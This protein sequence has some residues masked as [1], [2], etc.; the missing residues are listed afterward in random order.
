MW[1]DVESV[2]S[3]TEAPP[4]ESTTNKAT[5]SSNSDYEEILTIK[6]NVT[7]TSA[8]NVTAGLTNSSSFPIDEYWMTQMGDI[9][10]D[11]LHIQAIVVKDE[12]AEKPCTEGNQKS[13]NVRAHL[14]VIIAPL[15]STV[16]MI[17]VAEWRVHP[18]H[19]TNPHGPNHL[20]HNLAILNLACRISSANYYKIQ[21]PTE[22]MTHI[23]TEGNCFIA[24][25][26]K[27]SHTSN[28]MY[29]IP[30]PQIPFHNRK[31]RRS[32]EYT[33]V[34]DNLDVKSTDSISNS[35]HDILR[36]IN[37][38]SS[39]GSNGC[40]QSGAA[41]MI[42]DT[43]TAVVAVSCDDRQSSGKWGFT[44]LYKNLDWI[45]NILNDWNITESHPMWGEP[46]VKSSQYNKSSK[47]CGNCVFNF[48]ISVGCKEKG[49]C[50][51]NN[52]NRPINLPTVTPQ[53]NRLPNQ[54][55]NRMNGIQIQ[56][57]KSPWNQG[58]T[59][60]NDIPRL[61]RSSYKQC[62]YNSPQC[63]ESLGQINNEPRLI[64]IGQIPLMK[65]TGLLNK[66]ID[67]FE[68]DP[69][70]INANNQ[71]HFNKFAK[72]NTI[73][74]KNGGVI[75]SSD[76]ASQIFINKPEKVSNTL[77]NMYMPLNVKRNKYVQNELSDWLKRRQAIGA[78][79]YRGIDKH[80]QID[81]INF[82]RGI[83]K[84]LR[85]RMKREET[86]E[87]WITKEFGI[88]NETLKMHAFVVRDENIPPCCTAAKAISQTR[89][90]MCSG[91][92]L[93]TRHAI[94]SASCMHFADVYEHHV[95]ADLAVLIG[96]FSI[97]PYVIKIDRY[98]MHPHHV[99]DVDSSDL[100][101]H[102]L[103]ILFLNCSI[104]TNNMIIPRLPNGFFDDIGHLC[105]G[106]T[107]QLMTVVQHADN[108][109]VAKLLTAKHIPTPAHDHGRLKS[110][111]MEK[112]HSMVFSAKFKKNNQTALASRRIK[113]S[114]G[115][116]AG[117][118]T[119]F[120]K[121]PYLTRSYS[122][123]NNSSEPSDISKYIKI[124][125]IFDEIENARREISL[126]NEE[127]NEKAKL[128]ESQKKTESSSNL[129]EE[130]ITSIDWK[131][132]EEK[133]GS[134]IST[135]NREKMEKFTKNLV[136]VTMKKVGSVIDPGASRLGNIYAGNIQH[137]ENKFH[138]VADSSLLQTFLPHGEPST[139][140]HHNVS[141]FALAFAK[142]IK[143]VVASPSNGDK[144]IVSSDLYVD[145]N[146]LG[147]PPSKYVECPPLGTPVF[148]NG[149]LASLLKSTNI[150]LITPR[151]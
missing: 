42:N 54:E 10:D 14:A 17:R 22:A 82:H 43:Q 46:A 60:S 56:T 31:R 80:H 23:C 125:N 89:H 141:D 99:Y 50:P 104:L 6:N 137:F 3:S 134:K 119:F 117:T 148:K 111:G 49:N 45:K 85:N 33:K 11:L 143:S 101:T 77:Q 138:G 63:V 128:A 149:I 34:Q 130:M 2:S 136:D 70:L 147:P 83:D 62:P 105:C 140:E 100:S 110:F 132:I 84:S 151:N 98:E 65:D 135:D 73:Y 81:Q 47:G 93:T 55:L 107:C 72:Y 121:T 61:L 74:R 129:D 109:H 12:D 112:K 116:L 38:R 28:V 16:Q 44:D 36:I 88:Q 124:Q 144:L 51:K 114:V 32:N 79:T 68:I 103:A 69:M 9:N 8:P 146:N 64:P 115:K 59:S 86:S 120:S 57:I 58:E 52:M 24:V 29:Q 75:N 13:H 92:I 97:M 5:N 150:L 90:F 39:D 18:M 40:S 20:N 106:R 41:V 78:N 1:N 102:D 122:R 21:L 145:E 91:A 113:K 48:Y 87:L 7:T 67:R 25:Y 15:K 139:A 71:S 66:N 30:V 26:R 27:T 123:T 76:K 37:K 96:A 127:E 35:S 95:N 118:P 4:S 142:I 53:F 94:T 131:K 133:L 108:H 126:R 19:D